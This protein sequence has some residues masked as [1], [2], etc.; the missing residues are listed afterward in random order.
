M[1]KSWKDNNT[2]QRVRESEEA[3]TVVST[4]SLT[5]EP[6]KTITFTVSRHENGNPT[7]KG[8][9]KAISHPEKGRESKADA[10]MWVGNALKALAQDAEDGVK[11]SAVGYELETSLSIDGK[12]VSSRTETY[13]SLEKTMSI[14]SKALTYPERIT[15]EGFDKTKGFSDIR[16]EDRKINAGGNEK[17]L[18]RIPLDIRKACKERCIKKLE[19]DKEAEKKGEWWRS[20]A[21]DNVYRCFMS[22]GDEK[23]SGTCICNRLGLKK[24]YEWNV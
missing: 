15:F 4:I 7:G 14:V 21:C 13:D 3:K 6:G 12:K 5:T 16:K 18:E 2:L 11:A 24:P 8:F 1:I 22:T 20:A 10:E 17:A 19:Y 9:E 23:Y